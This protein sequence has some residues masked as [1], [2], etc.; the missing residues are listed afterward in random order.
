MLMHPADGVTAS[1]QLQGPF[2]AEAVRVP[3]GRGSVTVLAHMGLM[4]NGTVLRK[5][6]DHALLLATAL[7]A[8]P[9]AVV[10]LVAEESREPILRWVW[11]QGWIAVLLALAALATWVW[12][13]G[14][15]FGPVGVV[16]PPERRSMVEQVTGTGTFLRHNGPAAL[17]AAQVRAL[18]DMARRR[19]PGFDRLGRADAAAAIAKATG[20]RA[21]ELQQALQP[22]A[23]G[24]P[25]ATVNLE[26]LELARRRLEASFQATPAPTP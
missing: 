12:R 13:S 9:G 15:R 10:W 20:L 11:Q 16:P 17:H 19:L 4:F 1:W 26:L 22:L 24:A 25:L 2:G 3:L 8:R 23:S 14:V 7:Q 5:G 6:S 18:R 21:S